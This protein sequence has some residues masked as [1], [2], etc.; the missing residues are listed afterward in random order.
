MGRTVFQLSS[1]GHKLNIF[2]VQILMHLISTNIKARSFLVELSYVQALEP[3]V[4]DGYLQ[5]FRITACNNF[6]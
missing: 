4:L 6:K 3:I 5:W 1:D 2:S